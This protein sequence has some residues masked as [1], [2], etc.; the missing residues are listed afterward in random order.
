MVVVAPMH[1][2]ATFDDREEAGF[3]CDLLLGRHIGVAMRAGDHGVGVW[4]LDAGDEAAA[5]DALD[6]YE[7]DP[8][9]AELAAEAERGR[10][11]RMAL[12]EA[13]RKEGR[14]RGGL[15]VRL[16]TAP[17]SMLCL[18]IAGGVYLY[19]HGGEDEQAL[20]PLMIG[21]IPDLLAGHPYARLLAGELWRLWTPAFVHF[22][23]LHILF[24]GFWMF[25]LGAAVERTHGTRFM[26]ALV[27]LSAA[28]SNLAQLALGGSPNFGGLSGVV[29]A[30][31]GHVWLRGRFDPASGLRLDS[32]TVVLLLGWLALGFT[33][34]MHMA[35]YAHL[36][37]LVVGCAFGYLSSGH[38]QRL[39]R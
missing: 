37:G 33:G 25:D 11:R 34:F 10:A 38:L 12:M 35:N 32:Q 28:I 22:G 23:A 2:L 18:A 1:F 5:R 30:L 3:I 4:L 36:G 6:A 19:T 39:A 9:S 17:F 8:G 31:V 29:Y 15:A 20:A 27:G 26:V 21:T 24:N 16:R 13:Q 7:V 14:R